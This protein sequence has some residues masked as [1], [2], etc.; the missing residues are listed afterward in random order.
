[1]IDT[2]LFVEIVH[3][4]DDSADEGAYAE[5]AGEVAHV[6]KRPQGIAQRLRVERVQ[7]PIPG[8]LEIQCLWPTTQDLLECLRYFRSLEHACTS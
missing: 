6:G 2:C 8:Q 3:L 1:M 7:P 5:R 4:A